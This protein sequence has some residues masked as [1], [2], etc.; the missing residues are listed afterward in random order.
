MRRV[1]ADLPAWS[2]DLHEV[3]MGVYKII[4]ISEEGSS[5]RATGT[6]EEKLLNALRT[7][8]NT[9]AG[10]PPL[11]EDSTDFNPSKTL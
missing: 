8:A 7:Y 6:D 9:A 2:I 1:L 11:E 5:F 4:A 3:S 10:K